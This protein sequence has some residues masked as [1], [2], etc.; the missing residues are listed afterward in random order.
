[1][2]IIY[3]WQASALLFNEYC[4]MHIV[5]EVYVVHW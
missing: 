4:I 3:K 2:D 1:M 5:M